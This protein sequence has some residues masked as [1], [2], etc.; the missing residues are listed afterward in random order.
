[1]RR[2]L[3]LPPGPIACVLSTLLLSGCATP[4][5][6]QNNL[7]PPL[8]APIPIEAETHPPVFDLVSKAKKCATSPEGLITCN[9]IVGSDLQIELSTDGVPGSSIRTI[10]FLE[11]SQRGAL[12]ARFGLVRM[13]VVLPGERYVPPKGIDFD[14][15]FKINAAYICPR[16]GS[17]YPSLEDYLDKC[18]DYP[19][20]H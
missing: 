1:M 5:R 11:S 17:V 20:P 14:D 13:I 3:S 10:G 9:Y 16:D 8:S 18:Q 12:Y 7:S 6:S 19:Q 4:A 2:A 15:A